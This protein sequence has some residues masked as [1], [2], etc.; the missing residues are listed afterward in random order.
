MICKKNYIVPIPGTRKL[1]R[2]ME[3][4]GAADIILSN[5][6]IKN[7]DDMLDKMGVLKVYGRNV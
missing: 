4:A 5:E 1:D 3:N 2:L 6:E 7:I